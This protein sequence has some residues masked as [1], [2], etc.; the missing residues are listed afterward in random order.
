V[1]LSQTV[2]VDSGKVVQLKLR[3]KMNLTV[4]IYMGLNY[5]LYK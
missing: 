3:K 1:A 4:C 2:T 5:Y